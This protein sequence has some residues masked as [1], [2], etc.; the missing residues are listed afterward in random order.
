MAGKKSVIFWVRSV[1]RWISLAFVAVAAVL[2]IGS[3]LL[4]EAATAALPPVA[5][6][7]L[8]GLIMSGAWMAIHHYRIAWRRRGAAPTYARTAR[9]VG[10]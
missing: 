1:H 3:A 6:V 7:L 2:I 5:I 10:S 9:E 4:G 8:V